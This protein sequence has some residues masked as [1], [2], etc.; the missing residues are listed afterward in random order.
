MLLL[1]ERYLGGSVG[2]TSTETDGTSFF[3]RLPK[4]PEKG[5]ENVAV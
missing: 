4:H 1:T 3:L 5:Y 2:F